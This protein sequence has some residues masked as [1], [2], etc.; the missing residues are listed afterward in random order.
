MQAGTPIAYLIIS[1]WTYPLTLNHH[2]AHAT[3]RSITIGY[4]MSQ[5]EKSLPVFRTEGNTVNYMLSIFGC[6]IPYITY[7]IRF[8]VHK[9]LYQNIMY[10]ISGTYSHFLYRSI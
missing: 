7:N 8:N 6:P 9:I 2:I 10:S 1:A 3:H 5:E 4:I